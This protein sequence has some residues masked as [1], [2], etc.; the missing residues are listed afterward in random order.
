VDM[1]EPQFHFG[2]L[3]R[4]SAFPLLTQAPRRLGARLRQANDNWIR[5]Q[6]TLIAIG[7]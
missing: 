7:C 1:R 4:R 2:K 3:G 5:T 6:G